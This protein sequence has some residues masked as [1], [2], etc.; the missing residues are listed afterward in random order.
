MPRTLPP[1]HKRTHRDGRNTP[2]P[3]VPPAKQRRSPRKRFGPFGPYSAADRELDGMTRV[4]A[5]AFNEKR[6]ASILE[7]LAK[8]LRATCTHSR[9]HKMTQ[10]RISY[11]KTNLLDAGR[12]YQ[13]VSIFMSVALPFY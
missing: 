12:W 1:V 5:T 11:G 10:P 6:I 7:D 9:R 8:D 4:Q 3:S 2:P 13:K